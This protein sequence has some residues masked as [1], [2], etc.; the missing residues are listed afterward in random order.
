MSVVVVGQFEER[1]NG[2]AEWRQGRR[3][4]RSDVKEEALEATSREGWSLGAEVEW[5]EVGG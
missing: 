2:A 5:T 3:G 4:W 1:I